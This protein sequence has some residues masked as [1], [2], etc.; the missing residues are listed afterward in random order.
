MQADLS[1]QKL[2][3]QIVEKIKKEYGP[4]RIVLFGSYAYGTPSRD[5]D[6]DILVIKETT[7]RPIDRRVKIA[8]IVSDPKRFIPVESIVMTPGE[9]EERLK[10]GDQFVKEILEKGEELYAA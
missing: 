5:S 1:V 10:R 8:N 4:K 6:I 7:E 9:L 3:Q 2:I